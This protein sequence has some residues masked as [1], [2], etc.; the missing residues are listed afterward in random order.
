MQHC[1]H[2]NAGRQVVIVSPADVRIMLPHLPAP[3]R[4]N[5]PF[6]LRFSD[7]SGH[8]RF[9][10][11]RRIRMSNMQKKMRPL[12]LL[13]PLLAIGLAG[14]AT[15]EEGLAEAVA[16][17]KRASLTGAEVVGS[18]GDTDGYAKAELTVSDELDQI[19][20]DL[21]DVRGIGNIT[22]A[23][24]YR[25]VKGSTGRVV[26]RMRAANEGG[27]KNCVGRTEWLEDSLERAAGAYYIQ[28]NTS[29]YPNGAIRGQFY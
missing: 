3:D 18:R 19:C 13:V 4:W 9:N 29:E 12:R 25:G 15:V 22:S 14:C 21:N 23:A 17:T 28:V 2:T 7:R 11:K 26:V 1:C 8:D 6:A 10:R 16:E 20:Y 5:I 24:I 27:W